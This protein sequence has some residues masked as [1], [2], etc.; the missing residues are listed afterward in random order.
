MV[1]LVVAVP[2]NGGFCG[3]LPTFLYPKLARSTSLEKPNP[4]V[5]L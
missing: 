5:Y 3:K 4:P 2:L 1:I